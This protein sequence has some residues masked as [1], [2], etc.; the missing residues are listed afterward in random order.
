MAS[1]CPRCG[2]QLRR[3]AS[4]CQWCGHGV[5]SAWVLEAVMAAF[6]LLGAGFVSGLLPWGAVAKA[7]HL[8][9]A[10]DQTYDPS[11]QPILSTP[12][13]SPNG[14]S[15]GLTLPAQS[16]PASPPA[17]DGPAVGRADCAAAERIAQLA[18]RYSGWSRADLGLIACGRVRTGFTTEQV[19]AALG[20]PQA[21]RDSAGRQVW[22]YP[23]YTVVM[24]NGAVTGVDSGLAR[25]HSRRIGDAGGARRAALN[26]KMRT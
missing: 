5:G 20:A 7:L 10:T 9:V 6:L 4:K 13:P 21:V 24:E 15:S 26:A 14:S 18:S 8:R 23:T 2:G 12:A 25:R 17:Q 1:H 22:V 3:G 16:T 19:K 11:G